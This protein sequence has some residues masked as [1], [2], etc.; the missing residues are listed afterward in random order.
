MDDS[1]LHSEGGRRAASGVVSAAILLTLLCACAGP[2]S[3]PA[4]PPPEPTAAAAGAPSWTGT[5]LGWARLDAIERWLRLEAGGYDPFWRAQGELV[6]A[7]GRLEL[8]RQDAA[9]GTIDSAAQRL[10]ASAA[11]A[12]FERVLRDGAASE[13]QRER[14]RAGLAAI[15]ALS[16]PSAF[17][18]PMIA[19]AAWHAAV[20]VR[21]RLDP[22]GGPWRRITVHHSAEVPGTLMDGTLGDSAEAVRKIQRNHL[23]DRGFGDIGYHFLIDSGGRVFEGRSLAWQ[24]AHAGGSANRQNIGVC[25]LGDYQTREPGAAALAGLRRLL[26]GLRAAHHVPRSQVVCHRDFKSTVCPGESV[27]SWVA[28]YRRGATAAGPVAA[29]PR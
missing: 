13:P 25:L 7:E 16:E 24:G 28:G 4:D 5:P 14:A 3:R 20:P 1:G 29:A 10:R 6:L 15:E 8:T 9:A 11:R 18:G 12:G 17:A 23:R 19:R 26:D 21:G 22:V 2:R 27:A